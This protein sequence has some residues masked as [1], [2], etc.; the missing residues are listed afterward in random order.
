MLAVC[1][2]LCACGRGE[3]PRRDRAPEWPF[4]MTASVSVGVRDGSYT[5]DWTYQDS[6]SAFVLKTP[7]ELSGVTIRCNAV[8]NRIEKDDVQ[9]ELPQKSAFVLLDRAYRALADGMVEPRHT[10][11]GWLYDGMD[12]YGFEALSVQDG[13]LQIRFPKADAEAVFT[14]T[15]A[16]TETE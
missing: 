1:L 3:T 5:A 11:E 10:Q 12:R 16:A 13:S 15:P 4:A 6:Q 9:I 8:E 2:L 7:Q 14:L